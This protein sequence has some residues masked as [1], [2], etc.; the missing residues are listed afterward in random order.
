MHNVF[1]VLPLEYNTTKKWRVDERTTQL[2]FKAG[3]KGKKYKVKVIQDSVVYA[4]ESKS[5]L[6]GLYYLV[7]WKSYPNT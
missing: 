2:E 6:L 3:K 1:H 7:L 5:H 4:K